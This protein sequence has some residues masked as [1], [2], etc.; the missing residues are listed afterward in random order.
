MNP[1]EHMWREFVRRASRS[2][3]LVRAN[4]EPIADRLRELEAEI[5]TYPEDHPRRV[6]LLGWHARFIADLQEVM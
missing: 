3:G 2:R 6:Y 1:L 4:A 5:E